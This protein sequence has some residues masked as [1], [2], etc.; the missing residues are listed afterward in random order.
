MSKVDMDSLINYFAPP[1]PKKPKVKEQWVALAVG[2]K[3]K[4]SVLNFLHV[5][6]GKLWATDDH[7]MHW[8]D[9][10]LAD[11]FYCPK[12]LFAVDNEPGPYPEVTRVIPQKFE[13]DS[14]TLTRDDWSIELNGKVRRALLN[15]HP[16]YVFQECLLL[17]AL[18]AGDV[19]YQLVEGGMM[20]GESVHGEFV[21]MGLSEKY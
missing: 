3:D 20:K 2:K 8:C 7:R 9:T 13:T 15:D 11:G 18:S 16:Q 17:D 14:A 4:R 5:S 10:D 6:N 12:T 1:I 19:K 21:I